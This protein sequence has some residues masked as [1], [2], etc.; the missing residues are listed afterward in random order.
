MRS[1]ISLVLAV[2]PPCLALGLVALQHFA[3]KLGVK[4][5]APWSCL[6]QNACGWNGQQA[7]FDLVTNLVLNRVR[8]R[9]SLSWLGPTDT[10]FI[11]QSDDVVDSGGS[12][13]SDFVTL[14][15]RYG[16]TQPRP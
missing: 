13:S 6:H 5:L 3:A 15:A 16:E 2:L 11:P 10:N 4:S 14:L 7:H 1:A 8:G 9:L 12:N